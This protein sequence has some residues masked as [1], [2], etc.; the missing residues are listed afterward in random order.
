MK[1]GLIFPQFDIG[2]G[3]EG[4]KNYAR[5]AEKLR[6]KHLTSFDQ[7]VGLDQHSRPNWSYVHTA[8][9]LFHELMVLFGFLAGVTEKIEFAI[10]LPA[11]PV[12]ATP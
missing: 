2:A 9:D 3:P 1:F 8:D 12:S 4:V 5:L 11:I 7:P 6:Y 10:I